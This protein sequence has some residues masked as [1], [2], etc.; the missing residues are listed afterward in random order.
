MSAAQSAAC[1]SAAGSAAEIAAELRSEPPDDGPN[2][3][4]HH[5]TKTAAT[6]R[7]WYFTF[8][9]PIDEKIINIRNNEQWK[10][11]W[12]IGLDSEYRNENLTTADIISVSSKTIALNLGSNDESNLAM[13][14]LGT[15]SYLLCD[16]FIRG[17]NTRLTTVQKWLSPEHTRL[18]IRDLH[19]TPI[20]D[21][22]GRRT[23]Y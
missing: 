12:K 5:E 21:T 1:S 14:E 18:E 15:G 2:Q 6:A 8:R 3:V 10:N 17:K 23:N 7:T 4:H 16:G 13:N 19:L 20:T 11:F 9:V 22:S